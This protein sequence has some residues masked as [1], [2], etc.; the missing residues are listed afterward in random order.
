MKK[1]RYEDEVYN[2]S[3]EGEEGENYVIAEGLYSGDL[4][5]QNKRAGKK[6]Q[7]TEEQKV[8]FAEMKRFRDK[9]GSAN[10]SE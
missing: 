10:K 6:K 3:F 4:Y 1:E 9:A 8:L 7:M 5:A 2:F